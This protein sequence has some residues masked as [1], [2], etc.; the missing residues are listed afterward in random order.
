MEPLLHIV[1][2]FASLT[3]LGEKPRNA[4]ILATLGMLPDLDALL[5]IHR[6]LSHSLIVTTLFFAPIIAITW[7]TRPHHMRSVVLAYLVVSTHAILDLGSLTPILW[8]II[9]NSLSLNVSL[10]GVIDQSVA[11]KPTLNLQQAPS[12]FSKVSIIDYPIFTQEGLL[13][14]LIL[15]LP[16]LYNVLKHRKRGAEPGVPEGV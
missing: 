11:I 6:S 12:D 1:L 8:P 9:Q 13:T 7:E 16:I 3:L 15:L 14:A 2:P 4:A 10:N 5:L